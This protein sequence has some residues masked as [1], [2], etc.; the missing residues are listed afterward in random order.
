[1]EKPEGAEEL[2]GSTAAL[3]LGKEGSRAAAGTTGR[4][5]WVL[6]YVAGKVGALAL[7]EGL[8]K[9][10]GPKRIAQSIPHSEILAMS[11]RYVSVVVY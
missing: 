6:S 11:T 7:N 1:M 5:G 3:T 4:P 10:A 9:G 2:V 8:Q